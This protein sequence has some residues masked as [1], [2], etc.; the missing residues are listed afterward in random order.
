MSKA[1]FYRHVIRLSNFEIDVYMS[2]NSSVLLDWIWEDVGR[3][4]YG[5]T[6]NIQDI[7]FYSGTSSRV[8]DDYVSV[9]Q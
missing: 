1:R 8:R 9:N 5:V 7:Y 3:G 2:R 4:V 6:A